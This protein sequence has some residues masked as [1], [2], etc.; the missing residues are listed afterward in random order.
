MPL[1]A[2]RFLL[3]SR[4]AKVWPGPWRTRQGP[5]S[6][7]FLSL[8][9]LAVSLFVAWPVT[10]LAG[11][12]LPDTTAYVAQLQAQA[13]AQKLADTREWHLLLHYR[14]RLWGGY[15]SEQD[16]PGFFLSPN[17][18]TDPQA[19]LDATLAQFF[20]QDLVGRS[21]QPAQCAFIARYHWLEEQLHFDDTQLRPLPCERFHRWYTEFQAESISLIFPSAFLNNP[22]SMFGHTLLRVD[23]RGQ[24]EQTRILA[25]TINYAAEV[26]PDAGIAYPIRGIFGFYKGYFSTIPY[27][28]KVQ[29]YRDIENRDIWEYRLNFTETQVRRLLMHAWELG[30]A[31]F[32]YFFFKEN[33]SY[34]L[35][36]LLDYADPTLHLTEEF[37]F[38]TV[39]ADTVRLVASKPGL[40]AAVAYRP[41]RSTVIRRKRESLPGSQRRL[42]QALAQ[43]IHVLTTREFS[44]LPLQRQAFLLDLA[45]DYLRYRIDTTDAPPPGLKERNRQV[46]TARSQLRIPSEPFHVVPFAKQP[47]LGHETSR[48]SVGAGWRNHDIFEELS[49]RAGYHDLLDPEIG[50]TPD[51]QIE[52][53]SITARHYNRANQT[54]IERATLANVLSLSPIDAVFHAPSWK[55]NVGMQTIRHGTCALCSNGVMNGGIGAAIE[56]RW[57][58]REVWFAFAEAEA[59]YSG[60]Y[61]ERHR[62]GG[63]GTAGM[64]ADLSERWRIMATGSYLRSA[65]G[66]QSDDIRWFVG[67]RF[68]L[69]R[70]WALRAEYHHRDRDNDVVFSVQA[71]F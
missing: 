58:K 64:L 14:P 46:L 70:N 43:E 35:L 42:A 3:T 49:L 1:P 41:S 22:A 17:G 4:P 65:L 39:P 24:T 18:K 71:Y 13:R 57:I 62:I 38:W 44:E 8:I 66:E 68:T 31:Y 29:E 59:N 6:F 47:E 37:R 28:L 63:G 7:I 34:H 9:L 48:A 10:N 11:A 56:S 19:E 15:E 2:I 36:A 12:Q 53:A 60:A 50:Y 23:Q 61:E 51:A 33:C 52:L 55:I 21:Q 30:N 67:S 20:S 16:D 40:V 69:A 25:Y 27:Y 5:I 45:S 54:R 32:D 26:P